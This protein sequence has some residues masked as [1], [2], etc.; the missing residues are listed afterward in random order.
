MI[1]IGIRTGLLAACRLAHFF[2]DEIPAR[3]R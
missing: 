3:A 1:F 2:R